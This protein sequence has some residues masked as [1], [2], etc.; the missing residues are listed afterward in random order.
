V[1]R[2][3]VVFQ[4]RG[5]DLGGEAGVVVEISEAAALLL[6]VG[7][8]EEGEGVG[9]GEEHVQRLAAD[10]GYLL[11]LVVQRLLIAAE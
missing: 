6:D 7:G 2:I 3:T 9:E 5:F 11:R 4:G 8:V 1:N 10:G